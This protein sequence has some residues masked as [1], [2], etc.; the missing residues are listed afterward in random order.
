MTILVADRSAVARTLLRSLLTALGHAVMEARDGREAWGI[1][2]R[3][4]GM[5]VLIADWA[6]PDVD[7]PTLTHMIRAEKRPGYT[8]VILLTS[9]EE[10]GGAAGRG[11]S[12]ADDTIVRPFDAG[13]LMARLRA[14][15]RIL[16]LQAE[17]S[18][19]EGLLA[20]SAR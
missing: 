11:G 12:G 7:G 1:L 8:Y 5:S 3:E 16:G 17:V 10:R 9:R 19:L 18:R 14:A 6:L 20:G 4:P 15:E 2:Q 13:E